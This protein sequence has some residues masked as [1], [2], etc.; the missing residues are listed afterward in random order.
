MKKSFKEIRFAEA[1]QEVSA[2]FKVSTSGRKVPVQRKTVKDIDDV[3]MNDKEVKEGADDEKLKESIELDEAVS[4][5]KQDYSWGKM[6]TVH[7]GSDTSYPLHPEHQHAIKKLKDGEHTSFTDE[8]NRKVTAHREG[9]N[10]HLSSRDSNKK[11]TVAHSHFTESVNKSD[12]PAYL[13]K[14][15]GDQLTT[16]DL[17]KERTQNR[18]HPETIKKINGISVKE[19]LDEATQV[20]R[21]SL[22][23]TDPNHSMTTMRKQK[24]EKRVKVHARDQQH[25]VDSAIMHFKKKGYKV[26]D[27]NYIGLHKESVEQIEEAADKEEGRLVQLA[28]LGLVDKASVSKLRTAVEQLKSDKPL[29]VAQRSLLLNVFQ[30]L[31]SLVTGDDQIFNRVK[32]DVQK[33]STEQLDESKWEKTGAHG[34]AKDFGEDGH[35]SK[36]KKDIT[37]RAKVHNAS[38]SD[39]APVLKNFGRKEKYEVKTVT[40][41]KGSKVV[42]DKSSGNNYTH[43][44]EHGHVEFEH[45][46]IEKKEGVELDLNTLYEAEGSWKVE[47]P[48]RKAEPKEVKDKSGAVHTDVSRVRHL[49][50]LALLKQQKKSK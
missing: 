32:L 25:A 42:H 33:E 6:V 3:E 21:V 27:H 11:T 9:D 41:P 2:D 45:D 23:L 8:T 14:K 46:D 20:H 39:G 36:T 34:L 40:I 48:W 35:I 38:H 10:V 31:L 12:V 28:R 19:D 24:M 50:R 43:H 37:V 5:K 15:T 7:H 17:E 22:T 16:Q 13:R 30:D 49:A 29:S 47:T 1:H 26:H 4:V 18:S 44:P